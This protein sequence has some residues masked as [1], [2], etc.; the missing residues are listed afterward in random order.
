MLKALFTTCLIVLTL[1]NTVSAHEQTIT[2]EKLLGTW[3][4]SEPML[5]NDPDMSGTLVGNANIVCTVTY[6]PTDSVTEDCTAKFIS[7]ET[8]PE[9][10]L[11]KMTFDVLYRSTGGWS[12]IKGKLYTQ[13]VDSSVSVA[14]MQV[15]VNGTVVTDREKL[16][17]VQD[18]LKKE[19]RALLL[20]GETTEENI[21]YLDESQ[22]IKQEF[23]EGETITTASSRQSILR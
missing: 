14:N 20:Q 3:K 12:L 15:N 1:T 10:L 22:L 5:L 16:A 8:D 4:Y 7:I 19:F 18:E 2:K 17:I 13:T 23:V 9:G 6:F 11:L 21:V